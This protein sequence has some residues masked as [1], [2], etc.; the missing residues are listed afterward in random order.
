[1]PRNK[2]PFLTDKELREIT[3]DSSPDIVDIAFEQLI[4]TLESKGLHESFKLVFG[5]YTQAIK[6]AKRYMDR[7]DQ[8]ELGMGKEPL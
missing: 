5:P 4:E 7:G 2:R 3:K 8:I 1:M 6:Y